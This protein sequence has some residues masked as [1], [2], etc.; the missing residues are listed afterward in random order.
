MKIGEMI[1]ELR[2]E[3]DMTQEDFAELFFVTRQTVSNWELEKSYPDLQ[4]LVDM[5]EKFG[6]SLDVMLKGDEQIVKRV[7]KERQNAK[8]A[9]W[10]FAVLGGI[11]GIFLVLCGIWTVVWKQ[12]KQRMEEKFDSGIAKYGFE[13][14]ELRW[15]SWSYAKEVDENT[16]IWVESFYMSDWGSF[17]LGAYNQEVTCNIQQEER[18]IEMKTNSFVKPNPYIY[19]TIY[20]NNGK[21]DLTDAEAETLL[22]EDEQLAELQKQ[23][24]EIFNTL[25]EP[26]I[27]EISSGMNIDRVK[28]R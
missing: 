19:I 1:A 17:Y 2:K 12:T 13:L 28:E 7:D 5:S 9:R 14:T 21:H 25:F 20:D 22:L 26:Y 24:S 8:Y 15:G 6:V 10:C 11:I 23:C 4:T 27:W 3:Q 18:M 16:T